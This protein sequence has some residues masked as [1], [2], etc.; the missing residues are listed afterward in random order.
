MFLRK[1][2]V[3]TIKKNSVTV[4]GDWKVLNP[5]IEIIIIIYYVI[6][7]RILCRNN[8][9]L[10]KIVKFKQISTEA[11]TWKLI[12]SIEYIM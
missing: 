11:L 8:S 4:G 7:W 9:L 6:N 2:F 1:N 10:T 12:A 5:E 3:V